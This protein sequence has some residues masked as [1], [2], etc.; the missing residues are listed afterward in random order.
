MNLFFVDFFLPFRH[1]N[2]VRDTWAGGVMQQ[3]ASLL[4][5]FPLV[6]KWLARKCKFKSCPVHRAI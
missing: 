3:A 6:G 5:V 1:G 4:G 2:G